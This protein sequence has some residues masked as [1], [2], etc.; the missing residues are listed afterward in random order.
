MVA[1]TQ[2]ITLHPTD[3]QEYAMA[4]QGN[5][6]PVIP[7]SLLKGQLRDRI[8]ADRSC[9]TIC[10]N[11]SKLNHLQSVLTG[12][13]KKMKE[14]YTN[15][16]FTITLRHPKFNPSRPLRL[17]EVELYQINPSQKI[18]AF[19]PSYIVP[20][21]RDGNWILKVKAH[22]TALSQS[23]CYSIHKRS[24]RMGVN[25]LNFDKLKRNLQVLRLR[26]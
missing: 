20:T 16:E 12:T 13:R 26:I 19:C 17:T 9:M 21:F 14:S 7:V 24:D 10:I 3:I 6:L 4:F 15:T 5:E 8:Q 18:M 1:T 11:K 22:Q 25:V 23:E 2:P